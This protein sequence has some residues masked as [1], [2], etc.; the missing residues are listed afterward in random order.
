MKAWLLAITILTLNA[1]AVEKQN[2]KLVINNGDSQ[3]EYLLEGEVRGVSIME[4]VPVDPNVGQKPT[5]GLNLREATDKNKK[6][7]IEWII[8]TQYGT[9]SVRSNTSKIPND[10]TATEFDLPTASI[11]AVRIYISTI[12]NR[13]HEI[14]LLFAPLEYQASFIPEEDILFNGV[15]F[16]AGRA[17]EAG[18]RFNSYR[19]SYLYH[20]NPDGRVRYRIGFTGKIRDAYTLVRQDGVQSTFGNESRFENVGF[21]PL[22]HL[23]VNILITDRLSWDNEIEGSWAPQGYALDFRSSLNYQINEHLSLNAGV[24]YLDGGANTETVKTFADVVFGFV[25][26]KI[27]F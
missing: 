3:E 12:I 19:L 17:T 21:V 22:L 23:G 2:I 25:G 4:N 20:L 6:P 15:Q 13:K 26:I 10:D 1:F 14:R 27:R 18:Y 11:E 7:S 9:A 16:L 5:T 24:G 8:N